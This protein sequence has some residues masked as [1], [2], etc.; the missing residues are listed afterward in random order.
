ME[1]K[2][3]AI[4]VLAIAAAALIAAGGVYAISARQTTSNVNSTPG[5]NYGHG[6]VSMMGGVSGS[7]GGLV[8]AGG[9]MGGSRGVCSGPGMMGDRGTSGSMWQHM[10]RY[11]NATSTP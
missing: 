5:A 4:L 11:W 8:G 9:M 1:N 10:T 3:V 6:M 7:C 2:K